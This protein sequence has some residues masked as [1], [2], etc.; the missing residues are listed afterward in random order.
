MSQW[1]PESLWPQIVVI[2]GSR[3][4]YEFS[5]MMLI[6]VIDSANIAP[7]QM[8]MG[9]SLLAKLWLN[10]AS[11][12]SYNFNSPYSTRGLR[13]VFVAIELCCS[14]SCVDKSLKCR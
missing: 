6:N 2:G 7:V 4:H 3:F 9:F 1:R 8:L 10:A 11:S 14:Q 12:S 5:V 13:V